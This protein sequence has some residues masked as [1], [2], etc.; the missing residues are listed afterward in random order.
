M[1]ATTGMRRTAQRSM[2]FQA[3]V[4]LGGHCTADQITEELRRTRP[5]F[6]RSTVYRGLD[7]LTASGAI[8][9]AHLGEGPTHYELASG[10]HQHAVCEVC[11]GVLHIEED[12][13]AAIEGHLEEQH[14]FKPARTE[15]L[16]VGI[17]E[18]CSRAPG[19]KSARRPT[20]AHVHR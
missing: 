20:L 11:G 7:A 13:V 18:S 15:V 12:L 8:Y 3:I 16:V 1:S 10:E 19:L 5:T 17:C 4:Q 6:P 2:V 9:A 14:R